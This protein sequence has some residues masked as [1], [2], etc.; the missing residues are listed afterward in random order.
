MPVSAVMAG[1]DAA[2]QAG[3]QDRHVGQQPVVDQ[4]VL[5][6]GGLVGDNGEIGGLAAGAAGGGNRHAQR[7]LSAG[8]F[9]I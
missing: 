6:V 4:R 9:L 5:N 8:V 7:L 3:I 1:G 2:D